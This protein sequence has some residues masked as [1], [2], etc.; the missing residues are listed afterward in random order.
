MHL[1]TVQNRPGQ[2]PVSLQLLILSFC[3][4]QGI[5]HGVIAPKVDLS[6]FFY[7]PIAILLARMQGATSNRPARQEK[8]IS[9]VAY[10]F[11][12]ISQTVFL[13]YSLFDIIKDLRP[14]FW[15]ILLSLLIIRL[16]KDIRAK[17]IECIAR[18][19]LLYVVL[20]SAGIWIIGRGQNKVYIDIS[21]Q[22]LLFYLICQLEF[23]KIR[24]QD[25]LTNLA[26]ANQY[27]FQMILLA[28]ASVFSQWRS[29]MLIAVLLAIFATAIAAFR[30]KLIKILAIALLLIGMPIGSAL[31]RTPGYRNFILGLEPVARQISPGFYHQVI[32]KSLPESK[33][34]GAGSRTGNIRNSLSL[35]TYLIPKPIGDISYKWSKFSGYGSNER[36]S[37]L[38]F[39][40]ARL[41]LL[42]IPLF[43]IT[44]VTWVLSIFRLLFK[45]WP[46]ASSLYL[47]LGL[48]LLFAFF[49]IHGHPM[50]NG[51]LILT[52]A[53]LASTFW[54]SISGFLRK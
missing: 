30:N 6:D 45:G 33:E 36:D 50:Y 31:P 21:Y 29:S 9:I 19:S 12:S 38:Y 28:C 37:S 11:I 23:R 52:T 7:A 16:N 41:G 26:K 44:A 14:I 42:F 27:R 40:R 39:L 5:A 43:F 18:S 35:E 47:F 22:F 10:L 54:V 4:Y 17:L 3:V 1:I 24:V 46:D 15:L 48:P 2:V 20:W 49:A 51:P 8:A 32:Y 34:F 25:S 13:E 53:T